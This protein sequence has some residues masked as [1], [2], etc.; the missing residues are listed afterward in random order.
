MYPADKKNIPNILHQVGGV[1]GVLH[2]GAARN[3][4]RSLIGTQ[5]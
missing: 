4:G 2:P 3:Q 5:V 1:V